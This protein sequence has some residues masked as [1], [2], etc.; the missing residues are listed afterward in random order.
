MGGELVRWGGTY[1]ISAKTV[2]FVFRE[3]ANWVIC[4]PYFVYTEDFSN[5]FSTSF[6]IHRC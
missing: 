6:S 3:V 4:S 5:Y 2:E 1:A